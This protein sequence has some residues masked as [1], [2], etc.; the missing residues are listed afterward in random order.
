MQL[1]EQT[2]QPPIKMI[3]AYE[4]ILKM[5]PRNIVVMN[6]L[7]W[8]LCISGGDLNRAEQLS[9]ITIMREPSNP[10]YLDTYGWIM[11]NM[12]DC[13]S[14]KFYIK[15]AIE[16]STENINKEIMSHYKTIEKKC[17]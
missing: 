8:N 7:A 17:K 12:G 1:Y 5:D 6:N 16:N 15:R 3:A 10:I 14:A 11:Y 9:R 13:E 2:Q 4:A